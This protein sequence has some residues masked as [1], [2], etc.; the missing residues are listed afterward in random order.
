MTSIC[1]VQFNFEHGLIETSWATS[2]SVPTVFQHRRKVPAQWQPGFGSHTNELLLWTQ[3]SHILLTNKTNFVEVPAVKNKP[4]SWVTDVQLRSTS[5]EKFSP[6]RIEPGKCWKYLQ[7]LSSCYRHHFF[8]GFTIR[9][10]PQWGPRHPVISGLFWD[11]D[12]S[13]S[14]RAAQTSFLCFLQVFYSLSFQIF[15]DNLHALKPPSG[16]LQHLRLPELSALSVII[17]TCQKC[18]SDWRRNKG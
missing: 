11:Q 2:L 7:K 18:R 10:A 13:C 1:A 8:S 14:N 6:L 15:K 17:I 16:L 5:W 3:T 9:S 12:R 4:R